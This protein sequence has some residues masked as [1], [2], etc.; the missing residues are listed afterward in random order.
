ME[1]GKG[2]LLRTGLNALYQAVHPVHGLVWTD[3]NQVVLTDVQLQSGEAKFGDSEV[4]GQFEHVC[5]VSWAPP[6]AA[7]TPPLL[8]VQHT[9]H[10]TVWQLCPSTMGT[11]K[12]LMSETCEIRES[13]PV[14]PQGCVWH[15]Q[16]AVLT[17]LTS[18]DVSVFHNVCCDSSRVKVD[19]SAQGLVHCACWTPDGQRLVVAAGSSLH[20][21]IWDSAQKT[22]RRGS[23]S[24]VLGVDSS[25]RSISAA[26]DSQVAVATELPLGQICG[27]NASEALGGPPHGE[28]AC[29]IDD[30]VVDDVLS[31][32]KGAIP[33]E[34]NSDTSGSPFSP[35]LSGPLDLTHIIFNRS[36]SEGNA[37]ICLRKKDYLTGTGLDSS[38]LV[39]VTFEKECTQTRKVP[40][41]GILAPDL[42]AFNLKAQVVAVA[43]NTCNVIFIYA[44]IPSFMPNIQQIQLDG[45]ERP[46]GLYFLTEK[47]LLI[48][49]GK[50]KPADSTF[51]PPSKSDEYVIRLVVREVMLE[52][53]LPVT[54]SEN[55]SGYSTFSTLLDKAEKK[56]LM[57]GLSPDTHHP[58]RGLSLTA[59]SRSPRGRPG[60]ALIEEIRSPPSSVGDGSVALGTPDTQPAGQFVTLPRPR[61]TPDHTSTPAPLN[62]PQRKT[63]QREEETYQPSKELEILSRKLVEVQQ[64]LSELT[65]FLRNG[66]KYSPVYP[67]SRDLPYVHISY[68]AP[69]GSSSVPTARASSR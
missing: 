17:V 31:V 51:L 44:V 25:L 33:S 4:I 58:N 9:Q 8:A 38:H 48:L 21:Y 34:T 15:P 22:L 29:V 37:L 5:A 52:E 30:T 27:L 36:K 6:G 63:Q 28:D 2:K 61:S 20:S 13:L 59:D 41:P 26:G 23:S 16:S 18:Q 68:Q 32:D 46:K 42:I 35:S 3:G 54:L 50:Q 45:S 53:K 47:L 10:V 14:L 40:I 7:D 57:E 55:Q 65:D 69:A 11:S 39:L 12:W 62:F 66:K 64:C 1:L 67:L 60:S 19:S 43:S 24:S 56:K 49:V